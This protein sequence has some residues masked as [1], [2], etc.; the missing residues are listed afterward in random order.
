[1]S[2]A[3]CLVS[4]SLQLPERL[5]QLS[6]TATQV[7]FDFDRINGYQFGPLRQAVQ[8][9]AARGKA[10]PLKPLMHRWVGAVMTTCLASLKY[11]GLHGEACPQIFVLQ[12]G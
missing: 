11:N 3:C 8:A 6:A 2:H 1:M 5:Q 12:R 7:M 4:C 9:A 10:V